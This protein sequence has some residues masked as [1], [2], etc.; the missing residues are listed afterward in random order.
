MRLFTVENPHKQHGSDI[1]SIVLIGQL[2]HQISTLS[3]MYGGLSSNDCEIGIAMA[4]GPYRSLKELCRKN[5]THFN[6]MSGI[7]I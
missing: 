7:S 4:L 5:G 3:R 6:L 2:H 1:E